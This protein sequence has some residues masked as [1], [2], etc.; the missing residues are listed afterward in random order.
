ME[1]LIQYRTKES[2]Y[3]GPFNGK[4]GWHAAGMGY[5]IVTENG[6]L[7]VIDGGC[8]N[9]TED[10]LALLEENAGGKKPTVEL[11][12]ITHPHGDHDGVLNTIAND[13]DLLS[14]VEIKEI[15][16]RFPN[17][18]CDKNGNFVNIQS[19]ENMQNV[20]FLTGAKG[21]MPELDEK[22]SVDGMEIHFLYHAYDC[23]LINGI[24]NCNVCSLIFTV[25]A[26]NKKIMFT[27]DAYMRNMQVVA[28]LYKGKLKCN[29]L[30]MPHHALC[31]TGLIEFYKEVNADI[32]LEPT[33]IAGDRA[34]HSELY[35]NTEYAR[36]NAWAELNAKA[37]HK[38]FEG[39]VEF[40][41]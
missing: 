40:E 26:K 28:W 21:H 17:E 7:I 36:A 18:F 19:N 27:G 9:D 31:D 23:K 30:Q 25:Q 29:I 10:F 16:Y 3:D 1:K 34:M 39:T 20:L 41:L 5:I 37:V 33:C 35:C 8:P 6:K 11:W 24:A 2:L 14:R 12:I 22:I 32:V 15:V 4:V 38:T 13:P